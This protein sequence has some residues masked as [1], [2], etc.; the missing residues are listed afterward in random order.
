MDPTRGFLGIAVVPQA[1][2]DIG[3]EA[4]SSGFGRLRYGEHEIPQGDIASGVENAESRV[5]GS[6][7]VMTGIRAPGDEG[8]GGKQVGVSPP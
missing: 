2:G 1:E 5:T 6:R 3:H 8:A 7:P 4:G